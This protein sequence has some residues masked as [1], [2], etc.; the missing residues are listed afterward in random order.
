MP[1]PGVT[2]IEGN[3]LDVLPTLSTAS[4]DAV[5][6][7]PPYGL[8]FMGKEWDHGVPGVPFWEAAIRVLKPGGYALIFGGTRTY[9]RLT[10]A[11]ED[12]GFEIRD[13]LNWL[14]GTGFPKGQGCLKPAWEPILLAR[15]PGKGIKP[16]GIDACR[17]PGEVPTTTRGNSFDRMNDDRWQES[18]TTFTPSA[19]GRYPANVLHDGSDEVLE[20]FAAFGE[21]KSRASMRGVGLTGAD[22][23]VFGR[24]R[25]DFDTFR[26]HD[27]TGTAARFFYCAKA[28]KSERGEGNTHPTVKP[29]ALMRWLVRLV[30]PPEGVVLDPFA[31]SGTTGVAAVTEG[32]KCI[33][34]EKDGQYVEAIRKRTSAARNQLNNTARAKG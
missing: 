26:G 6:T 21:S 32:R 18:N 9:H 28:S 14:Y 7:D 20:A 25:P 31:G 24:G 33:L 5:V 2:V 17:V 8:S 11:V 29:L 12:A 13:C 27:D 3:C 10:C 16:L 4:V 15:K 19:A 34:V 1:S 23:K 22:Q 30:C